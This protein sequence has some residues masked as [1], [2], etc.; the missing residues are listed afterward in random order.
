MWFLTCDFYNRFSEMVT[1]WRA[2]DNHLNFKCSQS[3]PTISYGDI[4]LCAHVAKTYTIYVYNYLGKNFI[5]GTCHQKSHT[6]DISIQIYH[7]WRVECDMYYHILTYEIQE[8]TISFT[9][10]K[11]E[12]TTILCCHCLRTYHINYMQRTP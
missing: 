2:N 6:K 9:C 10:M 7:V 3:Y 11:F 1:K 5:K 8:R 12:E 4:P